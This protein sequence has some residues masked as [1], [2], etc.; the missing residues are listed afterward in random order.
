[1]QVLRSAEVDAPLQHD[2][3]KAVLDL[4]HSG[5]KVL[6]SAPSPYSHMLYDPSPR[7]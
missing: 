5:H 3:E 1:M 7:K 4:L 2:V 6:A